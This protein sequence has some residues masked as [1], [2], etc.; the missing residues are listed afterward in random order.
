M[1]TGWVCPQGHQWQAPVGPAPAACPRCGAAGR[2]R[3]DSDAA[4]VTIAL[5]ATTAPRPAA[6]PTPVPPAPREPLKLAFPGYEV[7][8]EIGRG[9]MGVVYKA[10]HLK[11]NRLV[12]LKMALAGGHASPPELRRFR[13]EAEAVAQLRH[14]N[15]VEIYTIGEHAG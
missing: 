11:L 7:L 6:P 15:I 9:S 4:A 2:P 12:A 5:D 10:R 3:R 13:A 1:P 14:P 8:G